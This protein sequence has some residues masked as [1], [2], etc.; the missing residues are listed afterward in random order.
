MVWCLKHGLKAEKSIY[1]VEKNYY[2]NFWRWNFT[3][4]NFGMFDTC[5]S[6]FVFALIY[7]SYMVLCLIIIGSNVM[8]AT[9]KPPSVTEGAKSPALVHCLTNCCTGIFFF[10][11]PY[12]V[13]VKKL[14][15]RLLQDLK[16]CTISHF[17]KILAW[18][19]VWS[20]KHYIENNYQKKNLKN[21]FENFFNRYDCNKMQVCYE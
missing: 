15:H 16:I 4:T 12:L 11:F 5:W 9:Y 7:F 6:L 17:I 3:S 2:R 19:P 14:I 13:T 18:C 20:P 21:R 8:A 10:Q 1:K